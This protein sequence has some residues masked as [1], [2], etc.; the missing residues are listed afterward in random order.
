MFDI[1]IAPFFA[2]AG[3]DCRPQ[4]NADISETADSFI[5]N[6]D[7]PGAL[8][9]DIK[10]WI[11][12]DTLTVSGEKKNEAESDAERLMTERIFGKFERSFRLPSAVDKNKV[13]ADLV[14]GVLAIKLP[15]IN[16]SKEIHIA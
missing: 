13:S 4:P 1:R 14:D 3:C 5:F 9:E 11:E 8:K 12:N 7:V 6:F 10:I 15:K 16:D 2:G